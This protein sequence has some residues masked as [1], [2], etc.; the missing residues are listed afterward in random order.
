MIIPFKQFSSK[1]GGKIDGIFEGV[2]AAIILRIVATQKHKKTQSSFCASHLDYFT[3]PLLGLTLKRFPFQQ[4]PLAALLGLFLKGN[5]YGRN[6]CG[7]SRRK[8][9]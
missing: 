6:S 2:R 4:I 9:Y 3:F 5:L 8:H 7:Y 1:R